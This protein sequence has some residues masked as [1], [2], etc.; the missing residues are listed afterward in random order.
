V[1][2][3]RRAAMRAGVCATLWA[4]SN[5]RGSA[6]QATLPVAT[7]GFGLLEA[8]PCQA[9]I[10]AAPT[11]P[12]NV[13]GYN[14]AT[15]GPLLRL[16]KGEELKL[17][18]SN[19]LSEPSTLCWQGLRIANAMTG[20][21]GLTQPPVKP[22]ASFD[23]RF[24]PP[25]SGFNLYR[26][27]AGAATAGQIGAGLY[28]P[29][30]VEEATPPTIDLD[31]VV[32]LADWTVN[33]DGSLRSDR[34]DAAPIQG[35]GR[36]GSLIV[37]NNRAAPLTLTTIPGARIRLRLANAAIAR[38]MVIGVDGVKPLIVALDGQPCEAFE[39]LRNTF[40]IG[41]GAR[42]DM[43]FDMPREGAPVRFVLLGG[44][45]SAIAGETDQVVLSF[46]SV[47]APAAKR[48]PLVGL[49]PNP[50]LPA[51]I[52]LQRAKR[53]DLTL[54]KGEK[55]AFAIN[56]AAP[57]EWPPKPLFSVARGTP[58]TLG[59]V[60]NTAVTQALRL[61]GHC[62]RLL[63]AMD[64]GWE[65]YWRDSVMIAPGKTSHVAFV[66]DNPGLWPIE[67]AIAEH[68]LAG[69]SAIFAVD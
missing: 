12:A 24:T 26:P 30:I 47:G 3:S 62:M 49:D 28:G 16:R 29:V 48:P 14:G 61:Y 60:N 45:A 54:A 5:A 13:L 63:H 2:V 39:P 58:V 35:G 69:V 42:F 43:M 46:A 15:P 11:P 34:A 53:V 37:A 8:A 55:T 67:S 25:D 57:S 21:G 38:I 44:P 4:A 33:A 19:K 20:V 10:L 66:A 64:D 41:P 1:I 9:P 68:Q 18:F 59:F 31:V 51:Q 27:H 65:P 17:R 23:Y 50:L 6:Q 22:G 32:A 40:P 7:D 52:E 56:G 36:P